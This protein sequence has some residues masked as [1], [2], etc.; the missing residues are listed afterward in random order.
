M[1]EEENRVEE[2]SVLID[3]EKER[4]VQLSRGE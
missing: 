4:R 2:S 1:R 3:R